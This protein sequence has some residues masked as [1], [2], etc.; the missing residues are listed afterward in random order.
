MSSNVPTAH[1]HPGGGA[2]EIIAGRERITLAT[3]GLGNFALAD[4]TIINFPPS[5][6]LAFDFRTACADGTITCLICL[7]DEVARH[8]AQ[9]LAKFKILVKPE[10]S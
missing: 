1:R 4:N 7:D 6:Q 2:C 8:L 10:S 3:L 9:E 5:M